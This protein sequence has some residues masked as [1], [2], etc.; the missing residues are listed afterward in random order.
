MKWGRL[1]VVMIVLGWVSAAL[2]THRL[3]GGDWFWS[4]FLYAQAVAAFFG[5][6][7]CAT[8]ASDDRPTA[9]ATNEA[10]LKKLR[11]EYDAMCE[12]FIAMEER[13]HKSEATLRSAQLQAQARKEMS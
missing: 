8:A 2:A 12:R 13:A 1:C 11:A 10:E 5:A 7:V 6:I 3:S 9:Y 4:M